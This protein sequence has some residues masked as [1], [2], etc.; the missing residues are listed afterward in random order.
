[1]CKVLCRLS[2]FLYSA[3]FMVIDTATTIRFSFFII[4][5]KTLL[6]S[7]ISLLKL[8]VYAL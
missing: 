6:F 3:I 5:D 2:A 7:M 1:M 8:L 4:Q